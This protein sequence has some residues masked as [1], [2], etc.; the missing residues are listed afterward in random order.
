MKINRFY[1]IF[2]VLLL[3]AVAARAEI[4]TSPD[5]YP[6]EVNL[7][8]QKT[9]IMLDEPTYFDFEIK[10][11]S[12]TDL[13]VVWGG[14]YRNEFGR[15]DS[16]DVQLVDSNGNLRPKPKTN[17]MGGMMTVRKIA[18][19]QK[20]D[21]RLYLPHWAMIENAGDY[22]IRVEKNLLIKKYISGDLSLLSGKKGVLVELAARLKVVPGNVQ[23]MG[24]LIELIGQQLVAGDETAQKLVPFIK[25]AGIIK[26]LSEAVEKNH[27]LM[28]HLSKFKDDLAL[29]AIV[30]KI[31]DPE[32][33]IR[34]NVSI[35]LSLSVHPKAA[36]YLLQMR[37]DPSAAI[38]L[39]VVHFLGKTKTA[40]STKILK[41]MLNDTD[42]WVR[43][44]SKRYLSER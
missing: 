41:E 26:Y 23:Q 21:F 35:S 2:F 10:N 33:E 1:T 44:E 16:F 18:A 7:R 36:A 42:R 43:D 40:L 20:F 14:D 12:E 5:G 32:D 15:Y 28:R 34:R 31:N 4:F 9:S 6:F 25:D 37:K 29:R 11:L 30:G 22:N 39:D 8:L 38:R 17:T 19:G 27:W 13:G 24:Q 3:L